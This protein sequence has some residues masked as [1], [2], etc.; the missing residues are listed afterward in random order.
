MIEMSDQTSKAANQEDRQI[1]INVN[2]KIGTVQ[3]GGQAYGLSAGA[4]G[5]AL[6]EEQTTL[7]YLP[8]KV[9][10]APTALQISLVG[11]E[12]ELAEA[13]NRLASGE[14][15]YLHGTYGVGKTSLTT[16]TFNW[17]VKEERFAGGYLWERVSEMDV[18]RALEWVA[19][20]FP[21]QKVTQASG[22]VEKI[23]ALR[24]LLAQQN[25]P[26][27]PRGQR[28][29]IGLDDVRDAQVAR[30][31]L[32][33]AGDCAVILNGSRRV[34]LSGLAHASQLMPLTPTD[35][36]RLFIALAFPSEAT[37][38]PTEHD[39]IGK[40]CAKMH[41]LPLAVRLAALKHA[42]GE[43]LETLWER[44][45]VAP[46]TLI[47]GDEGVSALFEVL[48]EDLI[49]TPIARQLLVRLA[50]FPALE[51]PLEP[52]RDDIK[53]FRFFQAKDYL[54]KQELVYMVGSN[55]LALHPALGIGI[56]NYEPQT[57][58]D[59]WQHTKQW[60]LEY[61]HC[62]RD[63]YNALEREHLNL[64][65]LLDWFENEQ[66]WDEMIGLMRNLFHYLRVRGQWQEAFQRLD[67]ILKAIKPLDNVR[68]AARNYLQ[69]GII[70]LQRVIYRHATVNPTDDVRNRAWSY[71]HRGIM[72]QLRASYESAKADFDQA[73]KLFIQ[74]DDQVYRGQVLGRRAI[75][76]IVKGEYAK[77][78]KQLKQALKWMREDGPSYD[79]ANAHER[80]ANILAMQGSFYEA[81]KHYQL[82]F[83][84]GDVEEKTRVHLA[85][86][87]LARQAS[88]YNKARYHFDCAIEIA[89]QLGHV[90]DQAFLQQEYGYVDYYQGCYDKALHR[91][92]TARAIFQKL[93][94][95]PGIAQTFH[96]LGNVALA[97]NDPYEAYNYYRAALAINQKL[98]QKVA[99]AYNRY[100]LGVVAAHLGQQEE[101]EVA[102]QKALTD[103]QKM[104]DIALQAASWHQLGRLAFDNDQLELALYNID[105]ACMLARQAKDKLTEA[106]AIYHK[107]NLQAGKGTKVE[108]YLKELKR[109]WFYKNNNKDVILF[110]RSNSY[111]E[112]LESIF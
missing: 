78:Q 40:I 69:R 111:T 103:A 96:A 19:R 74:V 29:L 49:K 16:E 59:G 9:Q 97:Q 70:R 95:Q 41:Y 73:D 28:F 43:S 47:S 21:E 60:L 45:Q 108:E 105:R 80:L 48:Y 54:V 32:E 72:H 62:H 11:R 6:A 67:T 17:A 10:I 83:E 93:D 107:K 38:Q 94:Y 53:G 5:A 64:I 101:A 44:L 85:W 25:D 14:K 110:N 51:A 61:A 33:A 31:F 12:D 58:Q 34:N 87:H 3:S 102:Y 52:L 22:E 50:T 82:A 65:G 91:F 68:N 71:L 63:D 8:R 75:L 15:Y 90:L 7:G 104:Q 77:A 13:Q 26:Q 56:H 79:R 57:L 4:I 86:G 112:P 23:G 1:I 92:E 89:E 24:E 27:T 35:A 98:I 66:K 106:S 42:D 81:Q 46:G 18:K 100:Q 76:S 39:L 55:R 84:L 36:E 37:I 30:A 88:D 99:M 20:H 109:I 2:Q